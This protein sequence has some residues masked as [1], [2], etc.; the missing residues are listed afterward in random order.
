[1]KVG[2]DDGNTETWKLDIPCPILVIQKVEAIISS[3]I[4]NNKREI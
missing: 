1:M 2:L 4:L 3:R